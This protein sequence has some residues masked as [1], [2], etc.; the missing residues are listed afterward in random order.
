MKVKGWIRG[1]A[2][3]ALIFLGLFLLFSLTGSVIS[4]SSKNRCN[5]S[6]GGIN[7]YVKGTVT[8]RVSTGAGMSMIDLCFK[9]NKIIEWYCALD[10]RVPASVTKVC[11]TGSLCR[12]GACVG[13]GSVNNSTNSTGNNQSNWTIG[14]SSNWTNQSN[15]TS[16]QTNNSNTSNGSM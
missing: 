9:S 1:L 6:D 3:L 7:L 8:N 16:N 2:F 10:N 14:N 4:G 13:N 5:D 15:W 11:P 12:N